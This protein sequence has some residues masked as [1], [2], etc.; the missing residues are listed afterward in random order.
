MPDNSQRKSNSLKRLE[1]PR[2]WEVLKDRAEAAEVDPKEIV[3]RVDRA[4]DRVDKLMR[5]VRTGGGGVIEVIYGL[6]GSGKTTFLQTLP[7]FFHGV[8]TEPFP[9]ESPLT[10][11]PDF[12]LQNEIPGDERIRVVFIE[13]RDIPKQSEL[14]Q[15]EE[16]FGDLLSVFRKSNG[17]VLVLWPITR[18]DSAKQVADMAW[19]VGRDSMA[20]SQTKGLYEFQGVSAERYWALADNTSRTL[21]G[22]GLDAFGITHSRAMEI[23]P[24]C[25]TITDFFDAIQGLADRNRDQTWSILK[26]KSRT[27]LWVLLPGDDVRS[28]SATADSLTQGTQSKIDIDKIRE[29]IDQPENG[30][31]YVVDWKQRRGQ[32]GHLLRAFDVR[33][34]GMPPNV[35]LAAVRAYGDENAKAS[36]KQ[37]SVAI[38]QAKQAMRA[39]RFYKAILVEAG[40]DTSP[41]AGGRK[42]GQQTVDEYLRLQEMA[43]RNDKPLNKALG[44]LIA[45]CLSEDAPEL[46]V[47]SEKKSLSDTGLQP[48]IRIKIREGEY[49]CLEPTWRTSGRRPAESKKSGQNTLSEAHVKKY[50]LEKATEYVKALGF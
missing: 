15:V 46:E 18:Y 49:I 45:A 5:R 34:F 9:K 32:L 27:L 39:S 38:D 31:L 43:S 11:L 2:R 50:V 42:I 1:L 40:M 8:R 26:A 6:S 3:E 13:E 48:D 44:D 28:V 25:R 47:V 35:S 23:L 30:S 4:A 37:K 41:F 21:N 10:D 19:D 36:L 14:Q 22:D 7:K 33:L 29:F 24:Q 12:I 17:S 16:L 20:D